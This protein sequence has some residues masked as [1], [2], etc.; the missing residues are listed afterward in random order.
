MLKPEEM[1]LYRKKSVS[2]TSQESEIVWT[3][4][5]AGRCVI[6]MET[7]ILIVLIVYSAFENYEIIE[8]M[9]VCSWPL[10]QKDKK[11]RLNFSL[12]NKCKYGQGIEL[13]CR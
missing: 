11:T 2:L 12:R 7:I 1:R 10:R 8:N 4:C 13:C 5:S 9:S 3:S 6:T